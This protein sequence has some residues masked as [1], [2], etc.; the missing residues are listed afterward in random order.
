MIDTWTDAAWLASAH[1]WIGSRIEPSAPIEQV[2]VRPWST[3]LLVPTAD[4]DLFFKANAPAM[5]HEARFLSALV[6]LA[7]DLLPTLVAADGVRGWLLLRDA[8]SRLRDHPEP[9][10]WAAVLP[11]YA[12]LQRAAA[13]LADALVAAGVPD[14]RLATLP[15]LY[16][17]LGGNRAVVDELCGELAALGLPETVDHDDLHDNQ[18][19]VRD[20]LAR[21]LDW[22][23]ACVGH[24][25]ATLSV[26]I[27]LADDTAV[28]AYLARGNGRDALLP[29]RH[30]PAD[31][32]RAVPH[33]SLL[34]QIVRAGFGARQHE[35]QYALGAVAWRRIV[36]CGYAHAG[37]ESAVRG[38]PIKTAEK[39]RLRKAPIRPCR[40][41]RASSGTFENA[42]RPK[43][44]SVVTLANSKDTR[45]VR[46]RRR[47]PP[48]A[49]KTTHSWSRPRPPAAARPDG[50]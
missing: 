10:V 37:L 19:F 7:P 33:E 49:R 43:P 8:G 14:R 48:G 16:E 23:D 26:T 5:A 1:E 30:R 9:A 3:V 12:D 46:A 41:S 21:I 38:R 44:I 47:P 11:R 45:C 31:C 34:H 15:D 24:P 2:H 29:R 18:V 39:T 42:S 32:A 28:A 13:P 6:P 20:G 22:G 25:L 40:R 4:G 36:N 27:H 17:T 50:K 35:Q